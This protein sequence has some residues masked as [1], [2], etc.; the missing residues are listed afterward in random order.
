[1]R[2]GLNLPPSRLCGPVECPRVAPAEGG[3]GPARREPPMLIPRNG[4]G[5]AKRK[6][7][8]HQ[9]AVEEGRG[10]KDEHGRTRA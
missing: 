6:Q 4:L 7:P 1:M 5:G 9:V 3:R 8:R 10:V 2:E